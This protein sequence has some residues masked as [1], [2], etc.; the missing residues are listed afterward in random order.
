MEEETFRIHAANFEH[1]ITGI[2][3]FGYSRD[4]ILCVKDA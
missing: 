1:A 3:E 4:E 2:M